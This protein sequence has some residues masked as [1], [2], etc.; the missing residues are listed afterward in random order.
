M[1]HARKDYNRIQDLAAVK[2]IILDIALG[3]EEDNDPNSA[4]VV[5]HVVNVL[6]KRYGPLKVEPIP[7]NEPVFLLRAKDICAASTIDFWASCAHGRGA[8]KNIVID[9]QDFAELIRNWPV[10]Q[11]PDMPDGL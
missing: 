7:E 1:K 11:V 10:K 4:E 2:N 5:R 9:A 3:M 8:N 6:E